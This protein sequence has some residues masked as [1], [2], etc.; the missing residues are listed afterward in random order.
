M[1]YA[2]WS[3]RF[4]RRANG[5]VPWIHRAALAAIAVFSRQMLERPARAHGGGDRRIWRRVVVRHVAAGLC[6]SPRIPAALERPPQC[7]AM[8]MAAARGDR[9]A[10]GI[11]RRSVTRQGSAWRVRG[12]MIAIALLVTVEA[13]RTP[14]GF[15]P[16]NGIPRLYDRLASQSDVGRR[17]ISVLFGSERQ[18]ERAVRAREHALLQAA[19]ERLQQ[20]SS[21]HV[22]GARARPQLLSERSGAGRATA[23]ACH[24]RARAHAG[25]LTALWTTGARRRSTRSRSLSS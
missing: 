11:R 4:L 8:G 6:A 9:D 2:W 23:A 15:T 17:R 1:H 14:V 24:P 25:R 10:R 20:L 13:I 5:A 21:R 16:F 18:P 22:R 7:G 3:H 12:A 19:L